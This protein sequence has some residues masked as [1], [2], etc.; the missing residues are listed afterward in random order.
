V[1]TK[2]YVLLHHAERAPAADIDVIERHAG[3]HIVDRTL[4][5]AMLISAT[6]IA[7]GQLRQTLRGWSIEPEQ[8][9]PLSADDS[10]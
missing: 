10:S 2:R 7:I 3:V 1:N 9:H 5:R 8:V 4:D 6:D